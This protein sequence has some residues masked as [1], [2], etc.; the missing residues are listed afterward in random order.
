M[1]FVSKYRWYK[2]SVCCTQLSF[3]RCVFFLFHLASFISIH[4]EYILNL[5]FFFLILLSCYT[6]DSM[7][8]FSAAAQVRKLQSLSSLAS[9]S[10][11]CFITYSTGKT[12]STRRPRDIPACFLQLLKMTLNWRFLFVHS[13]GPITNEN[14]YAISTHLFSSQCYCKCYTEFLTT[15]F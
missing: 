14:N 4:P 2:T 13:K 8:M 1:R 5:S 7:P 12:Q 6:T 11:L 10:V 3:L 9:S 15:F